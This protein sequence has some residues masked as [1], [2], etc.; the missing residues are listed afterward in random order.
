MWSPGDEAYLRQ[1]PDMDAGARQMGEFAIGA[2]PGIR[3]F[4][5]NTLFDEKIGGTVHMALGR[6]IPGTGGENASALH[7]DR[8]YDLRNESELRVDGELLSRHGEF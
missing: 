3:Q 2:N 4:T 6:S 5:G 8:V 7:W 1:L